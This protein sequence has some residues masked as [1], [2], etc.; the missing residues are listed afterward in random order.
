[1]TESLHKILLFIQIIRVT[2]LN[3]TRIKKLQFI[4]IVLINSLARLSLL[5]ALYF[6][7]KKAYK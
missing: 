7:N 5:D 3:D 6:E 2:K 1:M 4:L